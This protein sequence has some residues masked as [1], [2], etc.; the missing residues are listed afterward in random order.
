M[1]CLWK[2]IELLWEWSVAGLLYCVTVY[3]SVFSVCLLRTDVLCLW[4]EQTGCGQCWQTAVVLIAN[5]GLV[6]PVG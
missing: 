6:P 2:V 4:K 5:Y 1:L 3:I